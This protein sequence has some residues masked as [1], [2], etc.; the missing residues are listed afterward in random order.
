MKRAVLFS[1]AG[2]GW[3]EGESGRFVW[4]VVAGSGWEGG[5]SGRL[6]MSV[7]A[8]RGWEGVS[9]VDWFGLL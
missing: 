2:S 4:C 6:V 5:E 3:E 1:V 9:R 7:V 8:G